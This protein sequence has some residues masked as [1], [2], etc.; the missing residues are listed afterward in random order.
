METVDLATLEGLTQVLVNK[1]TT[2]DDQLGDWD[3]TYCPCCGDFR[4]MNLVALFWKERWAKGVIQTFTRGPINE[5]ASKRPMP[6]LFVATCLQ[7]E[8]RLS[9]VVYQ[10]PEGARLVA[11]P[12]T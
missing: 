7:C 10:G 1:H 2:G 11:L 5:S 4:R 6:S 3:G 9:L 12:E 8:S